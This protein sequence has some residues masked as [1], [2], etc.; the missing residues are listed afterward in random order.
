MK[1]DNIKLNIGESEQEVKTKAAKLAGIKIGEAKYFKIL[2]K[3]IDAR[4]KGNVHFVY[5]AEISKTPP[6]VPEIC[7]K[8]Y[9]KP[10]DIVMIV[11]SGPAG[12]FAALILARKGFNPLIIE[13]GQDVDKRAEIITKFEKER[14]LDEECNIQYGEG[15]AG[16]FS[17]GKLNTG[18]KS[19]YKSFVLSEFIK[20]GAPEE[21][22]YESKP[23]IGSDKLPEVIKNIRRE[24]I[25][26]GGTFKFGVKLTGV[27]SSNGKIRTAALSNGEKIVVSEIILAIGHSARD[28]YESLFN[29]GFFME[30]KDCAVGL[31]IEHLQEDINKAQYGKFYK[32]KSLGSADYKLTS[33][34]SDRGTFTFC[35]CPGGYVTAATSEKNAVVTNGMSNFDR[36]NVNANSAAVVQVRKSDY[37][38]G[39]LS[40]IDY[41]RSLERKAFIYGGENYNAPVQLVGDFIAERDSK[42]FGKVK[43]TYPVGVNFARL[44][45]ML[46]EYLV[47]PLQA[48]IKD[49]DRRLRGFAAND[50]VLT[51][52]ETRTSSPVRIVRTE[53]L[54]SVTFDNAYPCG[55]TG[56]AGGIMSAA[57]DGIK[58]AEAVSEKYRTY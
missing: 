3:S 4:D 30:Q 7:V 32:E 38:E 26:L 46:P 2:K 40:G 21:I 27:E 28:T 35:M 20:H 58:V 42:S 13:R 50:A 6:T 8:K 19:E 56:Y 54:C 52:V 16:T 39:V 44:D 15:G 31:R 57:L 12:L 18:V 5:S 9:E 53:K 17:D 33:G 34:V 48:G 10:K 36:N 49:M 23:H 41:L 1:I 11:G 25:S 43:P 24:I 22:S 29:A 51:G 37:G 14:I 55:E 45:K 47:K